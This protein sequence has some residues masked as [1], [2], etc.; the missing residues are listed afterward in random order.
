MFDKGLASCWASQFIGIDDKDMPCFPDLGEFGEI[1]EKIAILRLGG[2][3][4]HVDAHI[5]QASGV[6][7]LPLVLFGIRA[8]VPPTY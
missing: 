1:L 7:Q 2:N 3:Q 6:E 4:I 8:E 5:A